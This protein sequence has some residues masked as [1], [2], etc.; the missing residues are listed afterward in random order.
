MLKKMKKGA[1]LINVG[2]GNLIPGA[3]LLEA[4]QNGPLAAASIDV[5]EEE[6]LPQSSPLWRQ[7]NLLITPHIAGNFHTNDILE[8]IIQITAYNL[9]A[10]LSGEPV[11]NRVD[12]NTGYR[13]FTE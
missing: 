9:K 10:F 11:I 4:L 8:K 1:I 5:A 6:P 13:I 2:R 7:P 12:F 3:D